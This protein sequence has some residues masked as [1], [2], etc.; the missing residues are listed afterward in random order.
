M[1]QFWYKTAMDAN[2]LMEDRIECSKLI[3]VYGWGKPKEQHEHSGPNGAA[4]PHS[5][6]GMDERILAMAAMFPPPKQLKA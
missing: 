1:V 3:V 5:M 2:A 6:E 4:I